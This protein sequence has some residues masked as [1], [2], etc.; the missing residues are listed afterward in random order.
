[1]KKSL[2]GS[3]K[4]P[5]VGRR[6]FLKGAAGGAAALAA[7]GSQPVSAQQPAAATR[8]ASAPV[9][10]AERDPAPSVEV[11]TADRPGSDFMVDVMKALGFE[12][13]FSN[14]GSSFRGLH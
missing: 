4:K 10:P 9:A 6:G 12:V 13:I 5:A 1:M 3:K 7:A 8:S 2:W 11:L 14:P